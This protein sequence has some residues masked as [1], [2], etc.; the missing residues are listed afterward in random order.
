MP[1]A[2]ENTDA[3]AD[4]EQASSGNSS[5]PQGPKAGLAMRMRRREKSS[6]VTAYIAFRAL[7]R[8]IFLF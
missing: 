2:S 8:P 7:E 4:E 1:Q 3:N 5:H 6:L